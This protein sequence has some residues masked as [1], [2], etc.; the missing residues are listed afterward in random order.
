MDIFYFIKLE[1]YFAPNFI[2]IFHLIFAIF[3]NVVFNDC[4]KLPSL[5][6]ACFMV[7]QFSPTIL[8]VESN[9]YYKKSLNFPYHHLVCLSMFSFLWV[10]V[11]QLY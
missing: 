8:N 11:K 6:K 5:N 7:F 9:I 2:L 3:S 1:I 10:F 4:I